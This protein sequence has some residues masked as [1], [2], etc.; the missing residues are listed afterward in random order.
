MA[1]ISVVIPALNDSAMLAVCL[2]DLAHQSRLADE[3]V[4]VDNGST[5]DT[6]E[7]ARGAG[8]RVVTELPPALTP[9]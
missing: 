1:V 3:I 7:V 5:D 2:D 8:A 4:V 9:R 6:A